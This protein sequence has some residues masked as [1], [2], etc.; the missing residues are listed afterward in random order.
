MT[1][2]ICESKLNG[3]VANGKALA[4]LKAFA[5]AHPDKFGK[6]AIESGIHLR[7]VVL[8]VASTKQ[9]ELDREQKVDKTIAAFAKR[10]G[11]KPFYGFV[12]QAGSVAAVVDVTSGAT[13]VLNNDQIASQTKPEARFKIDGV[14]YELKDTINGFKRFHA[15]GSKRK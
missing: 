11:N 14:A 6:T 10:K 4:V 2:T 9:Q 7:K 15:V 1:K 13:L 3:F 5:E 8:R 12:K